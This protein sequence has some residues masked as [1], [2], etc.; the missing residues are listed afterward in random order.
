M[1]ERGLAARK[2]ADRV[3]LPFIAHNFGPCHLHPLC[4]NNLGRVGRRDLCRIVRADA[5]RNRFIQFY[6]QRF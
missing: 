4:G 1:F 6:R 3:V 5:R 2:T